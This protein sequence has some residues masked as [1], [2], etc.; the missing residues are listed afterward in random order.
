VTAYYQVQSAAQ[1]VRTTDEL[2]ASASAAT[3]VARARYRAGVGSIIELLTAQASLASA[4]TQR[5]QSRW[6]WA[7]QLAGLA[8]AAGALDERGGAGV[9]LQPR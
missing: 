8:Y 6:T 2:F 1:Q 5:A 7:L 4:R 9:P 3:E